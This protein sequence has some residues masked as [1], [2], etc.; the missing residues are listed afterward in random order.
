MVFLLLHFSLS[1]LA[2]STFLPVI[3]CFREGGAKLCF[4]QVTPV[5]PAHP[6]LSLDFRPKWQRRPSRWSRSSS[7]ARCAWRCCGSRWPSP[8]DTATAWAASR[9]SGLSPRASTAARSAGRRSTPNPCWAGTPSS[10]RW[11][12][13]S[14]SPAP[15]ADRRRPRR[16]SAA[17]AGGRPP[18]RRSSR[19]RCAC[20][21][22]AGATWGTTTPSSAG[23]ASTG[24]SRPRRI[25]K[26][27]CA[28]FTTACWSSTAAP[29]RSACVTDA[30]GANTRTTTRCRW[31]STG[32]RSRY[33][34]SVLI[35]K[36]KTAFNWN[37]KRLW[38]FFFSICSGCLV[39]SAGLGLFKLALRY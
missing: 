10:A 34:P 27:T 30:W 28:S 35:W 24:W 11:W 32:Q 15:R 21:P 25:W 5:G 17:C 6:H 13:S 2:C 26:V 12:R 31:R 14:C 37:V 39:T 23:T 16:W 7:A 29:T 18:P 19:A 38:F 9:T 1:V 8:A 3:G 36:N 22:S 33:R 4:S 20:C